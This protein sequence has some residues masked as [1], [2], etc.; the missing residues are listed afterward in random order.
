MITLVSINN[1]TVLE[2]SMVLFCF[3]HFLG[4]STT[5]CMCVST[6]VRLGV[7][8]IQ[9]TPIIMLRSLVTSDMKKQL[10]MPRSVHSQAPDR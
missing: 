1:A 2:A 5:A 8:K 6:A 3:T 4:Y 9:S 10:L 7:F